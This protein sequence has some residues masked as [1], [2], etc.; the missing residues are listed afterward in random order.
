MEAWQKALDQVDFSKPS[1]DDQERLGL[2][3][4]EAEIL[5]A[6]NNPMRLFV[7]LCNWLESRTLVMRLL[8]SEHRFA[9]PR[10]PV[11]RV[12][13][14]RFPPQEP[15]TNVSAS[16]SRQVAD[17]PSRKHTSKPKPKKR[18]EK[19]DGCRLFSALFDQ[20]ITLER[21]PVEAITWR[22]MR[23]EKKAFEGESVPQRL[24]APIREIAWELAEMGFRMDLY[25]ADRRMV[26][27]HPPPAVDGQARASAQDEIISRRNLLTNVWGDGHYLYPTLPPCP[28]MGLSADSL[29]KRASGLE[30]LRQ[31]FVRWPSHPAL[32][33]E[34]GVLSSQ[35]SKD[36][37]EQFEHAAS[38]YYCQ[39]FYQQ[40]GRAPAVPRI[41]PS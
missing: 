15:Q 17:A 14:E 25:E 9:P 12:L 13:L 41:H 11:W 31:V 33:D 40:F 29:E 39:T 27:A 2:F 18:Q 5:V 34:T 22:A 21:T 28:T 36:T 10:P 3:M 37:L 1:P 35:S 38:A 4:P 7:Y 32:F 30:G 6:V 26:A 19:E 20:E 23:L 8:H 16:S 24:V